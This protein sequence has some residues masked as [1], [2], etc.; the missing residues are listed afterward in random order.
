MLVEPEP[1]HATGPTQRLASIWGDY[2]AVPPELIPRTTGIGISIK[3]RVDWSESL[4][5]CGTTMHDIDIFDRRHFCGS[6]AGLAAICGLV[7][8]P[9]GAGQGSKTLAAKQDFI[10]VNGWVLTH[11]DLAASEITP[12]VI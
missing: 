12:D 11:E 8:L 4:C 2:R 10:V 9:F 3:Y 5:H 6:I 1:S 7:R